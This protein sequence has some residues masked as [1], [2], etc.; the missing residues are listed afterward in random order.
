MKCGVDY[1]GGNK[2]MGCGAT[3]QWPTAKPYVPADYSKL[4]QDIV[5]C[6]K[7]NICE[8]CKVKQK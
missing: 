5:H 1:H 4:G 7:Y 6:I 2:Q 3:F 8:E